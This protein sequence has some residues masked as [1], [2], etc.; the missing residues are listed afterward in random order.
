MIRSPANLYHQSDLVQASGTLFL[1][2]GVL[3]DTLLLARFAFLLAFTVVALGAWTRLVDAGLGCPDWPGCYGHLTV[4]TTEQQLAR[5]AELFPEHTVDPAK[6]WPEMIHRYAASTLGL[7]IM[8]LSFLAWRRRRVPGYPVKHCHFL[9]FLVILQGMFGMWT[10]T[11][12]LWPQVVTLHLLGG[13]ATLTLL[14]LLTLRL[15]RLKDKSG[16]DEGWSEI[17]FDSLLLK[18][19]GQHEW[20]LLWRLRHWAS[21]AFLLIVLQI[22]L[23]GWTSANYAAVACPDFPQCQG[24]WLPN[25]SMEKGFN[26]TQHV[27]PNYLGGQL[28]GDGRVAIHLTHRVGALV[29]LIFVGG[30]ALY[31]LR[32]PMTLF[33]QRRAFWLLV[34]LLAQIA[35][36]ISNVLFYFPLSLAVL[37]N[38]GGAFLLLTISNLLWCLNAMHPPI[39]ARGVIR[40]A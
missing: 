37:H 12:K 35:I 25:L 23:G 13:M 32:R 27:G 22:A 21:I 18:D 10:V 40:H 33:L 26:F 6:G 34:A 28:D 5:A 36:G 20:L 14:Y 24:Q 1:R 9:L 30:L 7:V 38:L 11:L 19:T 31:M 16:D 29:V 8:L 2:R 17:R 4:P 39:P 3:N 15:K